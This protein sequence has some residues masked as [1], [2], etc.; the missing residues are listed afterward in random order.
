MLFCHSTIGNAPPE[1]CI[2][3]GATPASQVLLRL[4][5]WQCD[6]PPEV[7]K[8]GVPVRPWRA[9][10]SLAIGE[11]MARRFGAEG[12]GELRNLMVLS[13]LKSRFKADAPQVFD[14]LLWRNDPKA[15]TT[16]PRDESPGNGRAGARSRAGAGSTRPVM[17]VLLLVI[18]LEPSAPHSAAEASSPVASV[19]MRS[20]PC[21]S[22]MW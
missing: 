3:P 4:G 12:G 21:S 17:L 6:L 15:P 5:G 9:V 1:L 13:F 16:I 8:L 14:D 22:R 10:D 20:S 2:P 19:I 11:M 7:R 18:V